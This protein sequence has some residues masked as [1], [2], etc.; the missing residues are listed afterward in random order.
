[1]PTNKKQTKPDRKSDIKEI[2][3]LIVMII[4]GIDFVFCS[5]DF[6]LG[7]ADWLY[8]ILVFIIFIMSIIAFRSC[9]KR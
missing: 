7:K 9:K 4:S 1:M 8:S 2:V 6:Y 5:V 3:W